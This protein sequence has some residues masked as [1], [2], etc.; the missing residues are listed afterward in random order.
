MCAHAAR[1][2][3]AGNAALWLTG[4]PPTGLRLALPAGERVRRIEPTP[5]R[6]D[7]PLWSSEPVPAPGLL[8]S[9]VRDP[10]WNMG[11][12]ILGERLRDEARHRRGLSYD[13]FGDIAFIGPNTRQYA[14]GAN[15]RAGHDRAVAEILWD[16]FRRLATDGPTDDELAHERDGFA[17][18]YGDPRWIAEEV[19][20]QART[21]LFDFA[22]STPESRLAEVARV[23]R[24]EVIECLGSAV[25]TALIAVPPDVTLGLEGV[26]IGGC[27]RSKQTPEGQRFP[28][29]LLVRLLARQ[30]RPMQL[31][32]TDNGLALIDPDGGVHR[33]SFDEVIG[34]GVDGDDRTV[35]CAS[36]CVFPVITGAYRNGARLRDAVDAAVSPSRRY[37]APKPPT[38]G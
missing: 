3:V 36:G 24:D 7:A 23:G 5:V 13:V 25:P 15:A 27:P 10:A 4:P 31:C 34:V 8:L 6:Q 1:F 14:V 9:G 21:V 12:A 37:L 11:M 16:E 33:T 30:W 19:A 32:L 20:G 35:F 29:K 22:P 18:A 38:E 2:F 17:E 26:G 28:M